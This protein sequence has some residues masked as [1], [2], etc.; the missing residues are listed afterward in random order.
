MGNCAGNP[1]TNE[2]EE[3]PV[4]APV[5]VEEVLKVEGNATAQDLPLSSADKSI[6]TQN[7]EAT[8]VEETKS[9]EVKVESKEEKKVEKEEAKGE[10]KEEKAAAQKN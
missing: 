6:I 8:K 1:K 4:P 2:G 3:V 7:G 5:V 9:E 10:S